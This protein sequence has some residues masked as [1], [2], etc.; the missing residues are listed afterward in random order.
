MPAKVAE[1][2]AMIVEAEKSAFNPH[3]GKYDPASCATAL[4]TYGGFWGP[5]IFP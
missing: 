5:W 4:N 3:R 1:L 2:M